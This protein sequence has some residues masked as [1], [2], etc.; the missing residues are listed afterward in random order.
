MK[1]SNTLQPNYEDLY[2]KKSIDNAFPKPN[3]L[4][5]SAHAR[6]SANLGEKKQTNRT[7][8]FFGIFGG[9]NTKKWANDNNRARE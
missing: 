6:N 4:N 1:N 7:S 9:S 8:G 3:D 2:T 5:K